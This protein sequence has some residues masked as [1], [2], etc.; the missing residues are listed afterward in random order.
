[1]Q[2]NTQ[3][4]V[5]VDALVVPFPRLSDIPSPSMDPEGR[6]RPLRGHEK[7]TGRLSQHWALAWGLS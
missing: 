2:V 5:C 4:D 6:R 1:M 7:D 3:T